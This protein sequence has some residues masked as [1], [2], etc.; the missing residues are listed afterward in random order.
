MLGGLT[1][2]IAHEV[3][4]PLAAIA[5]NGEAGLRWLARAEPDVAEARELIKTHRGGCAPGANII[6]RV[7]GM[8]T[9]ASPSMKHC[10][11]TDVVKDALGFLRHEVQ[12]RTALITHYPGTRRPVLGDR[13]QLQQV[14]VNLAINAMQAMEPTEAS[15]ARISIRTTQRRRGQDR[16]LVEG[17]RPGHSR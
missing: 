10:G 13:T 2:S 6:S 5:T 4:Q 8:A 14:I 1:A 3:N 7:R 15:G 12:S 17:Q 11:S 9:R 16:L